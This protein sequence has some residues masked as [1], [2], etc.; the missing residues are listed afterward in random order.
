[1]PR[2]A[3]VAAY[4]GAVREILLAH[5]EHARYSLHRPLG[6]ALA[7]AVAALVGHQAPGN[8][9]ALVP[10]PSRTAV[11]RARGHDPLLR[12]TRVAAARL[13]RQGAVAE[14]VPALRLYRR[15]EDQAGLG[16]QARARNLE[17]AFQAWPRSAARLASRLVVVT[18]DIVT[19]GATATEAARALRAVGVAVGGV[20]AVAATRRRHPTGEGKGSESGRPL[21]N[22]PW[23]D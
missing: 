23:G 11:V 17:G 18:D 4:D 9:V 14:V 6:V 3:C 10:V 2:P 20:A 22:R 19:T 16:T 7:R 12:M 21:P 8:V 5:K 15:P 1:M 13:R